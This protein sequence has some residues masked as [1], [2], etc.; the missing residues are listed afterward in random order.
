VS[1]LVPLVVWQGGSALAIGGWGISANANITSTRAQCSECVAMALA[2]TT[3]VH[4]K[5][6]ARSWHDWR[7]ACWRCSCRRSSLIRQLEGGL[8]A[9]LVPQ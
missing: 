4:L 3:A 2:A 8:L 6:P 1:G 7:E 5:A 9:L